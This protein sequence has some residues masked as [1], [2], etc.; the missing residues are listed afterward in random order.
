M[1]HDVAGGFG[2]YDAASARWEEMCYAFTLVWPRPKRSTCLDL[3]NTGWP[4]VIY[5]E[6]DPVHRMLPRNVVIQPSDG[7]T[8][9]YQEFKLDKSAAG[10]AVVGGARLPPPPQQVQL[11]F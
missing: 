6:M 10:A 4:G 2:T 1:M 7:R 5:C 8:D 3:R 11:S 9:K